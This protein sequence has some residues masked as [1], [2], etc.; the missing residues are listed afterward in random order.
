LSKEEFEDLKNNKFEEHELIFRFLENQKISYYIGLSSAK[1]LNNLTWQSIKVVYIINTEFKLK[2]K[3]GNIEVELI[4]FPKELIVNI[5]LNKT[6]KGIPYSDVEKTLLDEIYY[7]KGKSQITDYNIK[8]LNL[9][10]IKAYMVFYSKYR[11]IKKEVI[12]KLNKEQIK[13]L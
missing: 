2:R 9:E 4:K 3:I 12:N 5:A 6:N 7:K 10:K 11:V 1:Y 13:L 8:E